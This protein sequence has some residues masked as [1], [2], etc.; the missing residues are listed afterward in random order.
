MDQ[1]GRRSDINVGT[2]ELREWPERNCDPGATCVYALLTL[3]FSW[4]CESASSSRRGARLLRVMEASESL[5]GPAIVPSSM[6][7]RPPSTELAAPRVKRSSESA[8]P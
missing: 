3:A 2:V 6:P 1:T 4:K 5:V 7:Y 8:Q